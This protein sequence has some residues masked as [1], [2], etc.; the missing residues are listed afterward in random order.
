[1]NAIS[2]TS[3]AD[4][5][6]AAGSSSSPSAPAATMI[7]IVAICATP[8]V[9]ISATKPNHAGQRGESLLTRRI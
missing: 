2:C 6:T 8:N 9:T 3:A 1:M 7:T 4:S 5:V